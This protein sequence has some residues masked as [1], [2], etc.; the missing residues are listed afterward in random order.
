VD[1]QEAEQVFRFGLVAFFFLQFVPPL[2]TRIVMKCRDRLRIRV[3]DK[4]QKQDKRQ[5][6]SLVEIR[7]ALLVEFLS[8]RLGQLQCIKTVDLR[9]GRQRA[10]RSGS[11]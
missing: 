11:F 9:D 10:R 3:G 8:S 4:E 7:S 5:A 2:F 1:K 6:P